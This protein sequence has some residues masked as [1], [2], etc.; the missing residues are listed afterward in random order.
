[1]IA[2]RRREA[3]DK[4]MESHRKDLLSHLLVTTDA[5]GKL[6]SESEIVDNMLMLLFVSHET[7]TSAMTC[8]IKYL[9]EMP[10]VYEMVLR[11]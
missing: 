5:S 3:L 9:A 11:G 4:K 1:L 7:T 10:E 8:V 6:L 2:R